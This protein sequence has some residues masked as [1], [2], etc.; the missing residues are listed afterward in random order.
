MIFGAAEMVLTG[1]VIGTLQR[2]S[3]AEFARDEQQ[4]LALLLE[5]LS[6]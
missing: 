3:A 5:G 4:M 2:G 6:G 1:Y